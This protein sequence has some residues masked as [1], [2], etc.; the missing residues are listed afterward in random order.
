LEVIV[1][2]INREDVSSTK[3]FADKWIGKDY[4]SGPELLDLLEQGK[5]SNLNASMVAV[6]LCPKTSQSTIVGIRITLAPNNWIERFKGVLTPNLWNLDS[7]K[8][9]YFKSLF[10][11]QDYQGKGLGKKLSNESIDR[12]RQMGATGILTHCWLESPN[13]SSFRYLDKMGFKEVK[14]HKKFWYDVDYEC[15]KCGVGRCV[16]SA[17]EMIKIL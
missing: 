4:F 9:A 11:A 16:C 3:L 12:L 15:I 7:D 5:Q 6:T 14:I 1:R 10:I 8:V 13:N 2:D 17:I